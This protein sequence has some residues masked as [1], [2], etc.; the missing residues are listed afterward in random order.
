[1]NDADLTAYRERV[2]NALG[3][4]IVQEVERRLELDTITAQIA[5]H[6]G[7]LGMIDDLIVDEQRKVAEESGEEPDVVITDDGKPAVTL[8]GVGKLVGAD[9]TPELVDPVS[10]STD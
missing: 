8:S 3:N 10:T 2:Q 5:H 4:L 7:A 1:M 9:E 6:R